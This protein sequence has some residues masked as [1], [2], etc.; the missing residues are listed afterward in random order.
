MTTIE[1]ATLHSADDPRLT[2]LAADLA[3]D[4]VTRV[5]YRLP[6][7]RDFAAESV[8]DVGSAVELVLGSGRVLVLSWG[9]PGLDE[10][11]AIEVR[12]DGTDDDRVDV[13]DDPHWS[14]V[15]GK[16]MEELAVAFFEYYYD[17]SVRPWSFRL[18]VSGGGSATVALGEVDGAEIS[19]LP[20]NLVVIFDEA[21]ARDYRIVDALQ[22][23]W[24]TPI[25]G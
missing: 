20:D 8:H 16:P 24:G 25:G 9:T 22:S 10:G 17:S 19:Y 11:L 6:S 23:A 7:G 12:E 4:T 21:R 13:S 5:R 2:K 18:G 1:P 14:A 3:G 15:V